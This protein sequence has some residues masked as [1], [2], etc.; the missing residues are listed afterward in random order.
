MLKSPAFV[1]SVKICLPLIWSPHCVISSFSIVFEQYVAFLLI[2]AFSK[3]FAR[4]EALQSILDPK[5]YWKVPRIDIDFGHQLVVIRW[6][7]KP[8]FC[9]PHNTTIENDCSEFDSPYFQNKWINIPNT[10]CSIYKLV[11][12]I[13]MAFKQHILVWK[14]LHDLFQKCECL[15]CHCTE[16]AKSL[17][18]RSGKT[19]ARLSSAICRLPHEYDREMLFVV[20][21]I[22]STVD[23]WPNRYVFHRG[24]QAF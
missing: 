22:T 15:I 3:V 23:R 7:R 10:V 9:R 21:E 24:P 11:N 16:I 20:V 8:M 17:I 4:S 18:L 19:L 13:V 5:R 2:R 1:L 6:P 14:R 12:I